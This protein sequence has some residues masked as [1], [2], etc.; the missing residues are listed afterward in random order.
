MRL[1][2]QA[3]KGEFWARGCQKRWA[4]T[5]TG[6][7]GA[8]ITLRPGISR[9]LTIL[10][11]RVAIRSV[12]ATTWGTADELGRTTAIRRRK[13]RAARM[14]STR[15]APRPPRATRT[16]AASAPLYGAATGFC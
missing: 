6:G 16:R 14:E 15:L 12:A 10:L 8:G 11:G 3:R 4:L 5:S 7:R 13:P 1:H 2:S 9:S